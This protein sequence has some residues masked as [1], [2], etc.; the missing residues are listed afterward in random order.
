MKTPLLILIGLLLNLSF[1]LARDISGV[2]LDGKTGKPLAFA[3]IFLEGTTYGTMAKQDGRFR[4]PVL[5]S[6]SAKLIVSYVGFQTQS[7]NPNDISDEQELKVVLS[8]KPQILSAVRVVA[9]DP[10]WYS[11]LDIFKSALMGWSTA[12]RS[13]RIKNPDVLHFGRTYPDSASKRNP[14][15][16]FLLTA[17]AD[18]PLIIENKA[19]GYRLQFD[20]EY[21][22]WERESQIFL[23]YAYFTD[24]YAKKK[25][26]K[27]ILNAREQ[28]YRGSSM[29]FI[30]SLYENKLESQGFQVSRLSLMPD[31]KGDSYSS[32]VM[33]NSLFTQKK[34]HHM[35][36]TDIPIDLYGLV[37]TDSGVA[38]FYLPMPFEVSYTKAGEEKEYSSNWIGFYRTEHQQTTLIRLMKDRLVFYG[39]G[40]MQNPYE[41]LTLG[42]WSFKKLGDML[43]LDYVPASIPDEE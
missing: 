29:H 19:L 11:N 20:L 43:P 39:D 9:K 13:C 5:K 24:L 23:G 12:G 37:K 25:I 36:Q 6:T 1:T 27:R 4:L 8:P 3:T 26:P 10:N 41:M 22:T 15:S 38:R 34:D 30:R 35:V 18:E 33:G 42:Y 7:F 17:T 16:P 2:V 40:G 31:L 21:F 32:R 28:V 14:N